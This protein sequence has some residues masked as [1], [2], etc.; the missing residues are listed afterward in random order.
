MTS[1]HITGTH[2]AYLHL[3]HR[4][5]WLFAHGI[6]M[7]QE[8]ELVAEGRLIGESSYPQR[9]ER[10]QEIA[11]EGIKIDH[12]DAALCLVREVKKSNKR[13][14]AH[15][16]QLKYYLFVLERNQ[17]PARHGI[18]EYP[19]LRRTEE[20]WLDEEDRR[21]IPGWEAEVRRIVDAETCPP[22][23]KKTICRR[24]AYHDFCYINEPT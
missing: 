1:I 9:A 23:V 18:L 20:V 22:L 2:I 17:I 24:C 7:E 6:G 8:S 16:A 19:A 13:E 15:V 12:Y 10:W 5:L 11:V 4:K 14:D 3:C 21:A